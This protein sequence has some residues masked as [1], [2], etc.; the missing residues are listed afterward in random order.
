MKRIFLIAAIA[1]VGTAA[2]AQKKNVKIA[3]IA[4]WD[5]ETPNFTEARQCIQAAMLDP[6]TANQAKTYQVAGLVEI[7]YFKCN[8]GTL[9]DD[10]YNALRTAYPYLMKAIELEKIPDEKGKVS[11][12][13]TKAIAKELESIQEY[14]YYG[15]GHFI[16]NGDQKAAYEMF[17][18]MGELCQQDFMANSKINCQDTM[19][20]QA[21]Y[22]AAMTAVQLGNY[23]DALKSLDVAKEDNY[24]ILDIYNA[25][26]YVYEQTK[27][28][29]N[30]I[31][32]F[33]EGL[34]NFG[35]EVNSKEYAFLARL[36]NIYINQD[37]VPE[38]IA[39]IEEALVDSPDDCEY[40][41]LLGSLYYEQKNEEKAIEVLK[42]A[43]DTDPT[44]AA[45][46]G[47]LGRIF[48]NNA[49][50]ISNEVSEIQDNNAY[51]KAREEKVKPAFL[52][53]APYFEKALELD[54]SETTYMYSLKN[55]YYNAEDGANL[56]RIENMMGE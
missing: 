42:K 36:I 53:A 3:E 25:Y 14:Y 20:M 21:R 55:I 37:N 7:N 19:H 35:S 43:I 39:L 1:I 34:K 22:F 26:A 45:A 23:E 18:I 27:D 30:L 51:H 4:T 16:N 31:A 56:E 33:K 40:M 9:N 12:K 13:L 24:N 44:Y 15:G 17:K 47:E 5:M 50:T 11:T 2:F 28:T 38:A 8:S 6:T 29:T 49:I 32:T 54:P 41:K 52:K 46:Y 48:Y 10:V